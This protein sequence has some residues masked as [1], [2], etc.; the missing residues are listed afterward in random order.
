MK[1]IMIAIKK[2]VTLF[3][4]LGSFFSAS[5]QDNMLNLPDALQKALKNNYGITILKSE[6]EI[7]SLNNNW[8]TAG[9][10]PTLGLDISSTNNADLLNNSSSNRISGGIGVNWTLFDGFRVNVTKDKLA[11]LENLAQGRLAVVVENTIQDVILGY[12]NVLLQKEQLLVLKKVMSLSRDRYE[13]ELMRRELG[14]SLTYNV[15][16]SKNIYL[17]DSAAYLNQ[18]VIVRNAKRNLN[19]VLGVEPET[20][21]QF[22]ESFESDTVDYELGDLLNK[23][24]LSNQTLQNQYIN[25][26]LQKDEVKLSKSA[27]YPSVRLSA[28]LDNSWSRLNN[29]GIDP[30][31]SETVTPYGNVTLSYDIFTGGNRKRAIQV[32]RINKEIAAIENEEIKHSLTNQLYN[33]YDL[34]NVRKTLLGVAEEGLEAAELNLEIAGKKFKAGAINSFNYRD[35][36]LIYVNAALQKLRATYDLISSNTNLTRLTGGFVN[37]EEE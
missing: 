2:I 22:T 25:L 26:R 27:M 17:E 18:Q 21:F 11:K 4:F 32:A 1:E 6:R 13:Y 10:Y 36:Q 28:G 33:V 31:T 9:R 24:L 8:G 15:L 30:S 23:M 3:I 7:A 16:Q 29:Q 12:Y 19:F 5:S 20:N 35:I 37:E 34:Y 14:K